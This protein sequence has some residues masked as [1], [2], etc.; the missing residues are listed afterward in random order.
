MAETVLITGAN[1]GIGLEF[2]RQYV[3]DGWTVMAT[4]RNP[5]GAEDLRA[6]ARRHGDPVRVLE[7]DVASEESVTRAQQGLRGEQI[8]L[9]I[10]NAG[11]MGGGGSIHKVGPDEVRRVLETNLLGPYRVTRALLP[12]VQRGRGRKIVFITSLMGSMGDGPSGGS[13]PYRLSKAALN[14]LGANLAAELRGRGIISVLL[15][16]GWVMTRMGGPSAPTSVE[17][18]VRG[19][20]A[21]IS[22]L[23]PED[24]GKFFH[25]QGHELPW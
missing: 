10:N 8:D 17:E 24:S 22:R 23:A 5:G 6:L 11:V 16:P 7:M 4:A 20:R 1:R 9:L 14:M 2:V 19:M 13:Y 21:V 18:S 12:C 3:E 25:A 15:H